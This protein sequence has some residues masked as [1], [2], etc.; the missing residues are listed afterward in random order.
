MFKFFNL[1]SVVEVNKDDLWSVEGNIVLET[2]FVMLCLAGI[3]IINSVTMLSQ[4]F[5]LDLFHIGT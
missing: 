2:V 1:V 3:V 4:L 5:G